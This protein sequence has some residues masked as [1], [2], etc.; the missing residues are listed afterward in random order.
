MPQRS[1]LHSLEFLKSLQLPNGGF[2]YHVGEEAQPDATAW[3]I[4]AMS[5]CEFARESVARG[6][7]YLV[8]QQAPDGGVSISPTH[9]EASWPTPLAIL[10]WQ[11]SSDFEQAQELAVHFLLNFSG[12]HIPK[13]TGRYRGHDPSILGWPWVSDTHSWVLPTALAMIALQKVRLST[14][15][16]VTEG[17]QMLLNRQLKHGG[18]NYG[19]TMVFG[20]ELHPLPECTGIALQALAGMT[21]TTEIERSLSY[22]L[23]ELS[24]L[25]T[26]IS[27]GWTIL[28]LGAWRLK[29]AN[30]EELVWACLQRQE[31]YGLYSLPSLALLLCAA[32]ASQGFHSLFGSSPQKPPPSVHH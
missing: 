27:L 9:P 32:I 13:P 23:Q 17:Q 28:G 20:K 18:W 19:N 2:P 29:P 12:H 26:P 22:L 30:T 25:R 10:A 31:R 14:H 6:R 8:S 21:P 7:A 11:G 15:S 4:I 16:R 24:C 5:A 1:F 3:A